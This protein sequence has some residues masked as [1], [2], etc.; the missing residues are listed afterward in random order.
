M[1]D[2]LFL[3]SVIDMRIK[4]FSHFTDFTIRSMHRFYRS[5]VVDMLA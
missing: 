5:S 3:L 2:F 4:P 1:A